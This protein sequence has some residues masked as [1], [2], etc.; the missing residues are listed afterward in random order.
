MRGSPHNA[1]EFFAGPAQGVDALSSCSPHRP[2]RQQL[3]WPAV[4]DVSG[5][6]LAPVV[7]DVTP[8]VIRLQRQPSGAGLRQVRLTALSRKFNK[9]G[10]HGFANSNA[11][12]VSSWSCLRRARQCD[13]VI[14]LLAFIDD[15]CTGCE[16]HLQVLPQVQVH[17]AGGASDVHPMGNLQPLRSGSSAHIA[18]VDGASERRSAG[19]SWPTAAVAR[20]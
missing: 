4:C 1:G 9:G 10:A 8:L 16:L 5:K 11:V 7:V 15:N 2:L 19:E 13:R 3:S 18:S 17:G 6:N 14:D 12:I 20:R